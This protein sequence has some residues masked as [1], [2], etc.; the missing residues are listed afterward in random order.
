M[1]VRIEFDN[2]RLDAESIY[3][4]VELTTKHAGFLDGWSSAVSDI[5]SASS[6]IKECIL[7]GALLDCE[8][9]EGMKSMVSMRKGEVRGLCDYLLE[10]LEE[11][12]KQPENPQ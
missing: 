10:I 9:W 1:K 5:L 7:L 2:D 4:A 8:R 6:Y 3:G 11:H 12:D